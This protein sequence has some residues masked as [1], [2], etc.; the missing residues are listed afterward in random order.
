MG[1]SCVHLDVLQTSHHGVLHTEM[2]QQC[3]P[4]TCKN[5]EV[6][7][8]LYWNEHAPISA[9]LVHHLTE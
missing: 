5:S 1:Y 3:A 7:E 4:V 6:A 2:Y 9:W 8:H